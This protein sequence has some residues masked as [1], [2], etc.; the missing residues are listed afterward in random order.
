MNAKKLN[1]NPY[2]VLVQMLIDEPIDEKLQTLI[3][4][5]TK[6]NDVY[7]KGNVVYVDLSK[8]FI[9]NEEGDI[10][11]EENII[12]SMVDTLTELNEVT[13]LKILIDGSEDKEQGYGSEVYEVAQVDYPAR[14]ARIMGVSTD[15]AN[16]IDYRSVREEGSK[17]VKA[18][19]EQSATE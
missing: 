19:K 13:Y 16:G 17:E 4:K 11:K 7:I 1:E 18:V 9:E 6:I 8:E 15:R 14:H 2:S 12:N 5:G 10:K 3:P